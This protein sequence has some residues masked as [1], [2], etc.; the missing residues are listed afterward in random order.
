M[1]MK[2]MI[3][4][5]QYPCDFKMNKHQNETDR[6]ELS[7]RVVWPL[8][9]HQFKA[10]KSNITLKKVDGHGEQDEHCDYQTCILK[11]ASP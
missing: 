10:T 7:V 4:L 1:I 9:S 11:R 5:E 2:N 8:S 3:L 6:Q